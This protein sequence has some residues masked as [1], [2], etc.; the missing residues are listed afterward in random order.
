MLAL[1]LHN[2]VV[3]VT[4]HQDDLLLLTEV[5]TYISHLKRVLKLTFPALAAPQIL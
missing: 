2:T 5:I 3:T 4:I 1:L